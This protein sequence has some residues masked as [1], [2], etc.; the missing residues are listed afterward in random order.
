[1]PLSV[2]QKQVYDLISRIPR[3]RIS[4]YR[5]VARALDK[6]RAS[7][8]VG[9]ALHNNPFAPQVP[10][11]RIIKSDGRVGGY[12]GGPEKKQAM[13]KKEGVKIIDGW[14][15]LKKYGYEF[16]SKK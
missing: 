3:G 8:A 12:G 16:A 15:D 4:T 7:R 10:C 9:N 6:P 14:I 11:H 2:F 1:M 5:A 13:L